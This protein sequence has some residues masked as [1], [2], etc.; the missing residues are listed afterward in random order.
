[1][2]DVSCPAIARLKADEVEPGKFAQLAVEMLKGR[3]SELASLNLRDISD[4]CPQGIQRHRVFRSS[5]V[6]R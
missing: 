4:T 6:F 5:Q 2:S 1:M 3:L